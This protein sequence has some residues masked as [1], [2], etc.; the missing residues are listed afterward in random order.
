MEAGSDHWIRKVRST[1][2]ARLAS[3]E[4]G[5]SLIICTAALQYVHMWHLCP[6]SLLSSPRCHWE[7]PNGRHPCRS[8]PP[9]CLLCLGMLLRSTRRSTRRRLL[10][11]LQLPRLLCCVRAAVAA[12]RPGPRLPRRRALLRCAPAPGLRLGTPALSST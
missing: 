6:V 8:V 4:N 10:R 1:T 5:K 12:L 9:R 11:N 7:G 3:L 2:S